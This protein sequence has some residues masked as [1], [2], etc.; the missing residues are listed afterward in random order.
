MTNCVTSFDMGTRTTSN[1]NHWTG[2]LTVG[3]KDKEKK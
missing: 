3:R 1:K 2:Q